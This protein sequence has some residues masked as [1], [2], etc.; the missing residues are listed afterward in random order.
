M[1]D[2]GDGLSVHHRHDDDIF[3]SIFNV[4]INR[5]PAPTRVIGLH[6]RRGKMLDARRPEAATEKNDQLAVRLECEAFPHRADGGAAP[7]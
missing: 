1:Q 4:H 2:C 5:M 7:A 6:Y 3:L